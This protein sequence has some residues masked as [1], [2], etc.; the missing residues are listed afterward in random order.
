MRF[1]IVF[2]FLLF[3]YSPQAFAQ[4]VNPAGV[5]GEVQFN[6]SHD[7]FQGCTSRG[8][9]A[10][11]PPALAADDTP[12]VF[13]FTDQTAAATSTIII[14]NSVTITGIDA[15]TAV[16]ISGAGTPEFRING[17]S[18]VTNGAITDGQTLELRLTSN[19]AAS[20]M[21]SATVTVG[22]LSD[23][24]DVTTG[25]GCPATPSSG[26]EGCDMPDGSIYAGESPDGNVAMYTTPADAGQFSWNNG[27]S[28]W[29]DIAMVNCTGAQASC[30]TG[31]ANTALLVGLG[32]SPSPAPYVAA[33]H[34]DNLTAHGHSDWYLPA[35]TELA[36]LRTNRVAIGAFNISGSF[37]AGWY[38]SS[39]ESSNAL[40]WNQRFSDG[41]QSLFNLKFGDLS[42]RCVRR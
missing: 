2:I 42:V 30:D 4:C 36:V 21:N 28:T 14:S 1:F 13:G 3:S 25:T 23:Q 22:T 6:T 24:W 31:E 26:D 17:G 9:M 20:T 39:S 5:P 40:S 12:D 19:A 8:W 41:T 38:W 7:V 18:W 16:T 29:L 11:H 32:T 15:A 34:C 35:S 37:P 27:T 10:F 33:R